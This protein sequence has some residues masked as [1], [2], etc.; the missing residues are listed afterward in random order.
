MEYKGY[1]IDDSFGD[2]YTVCYCGDEIAF[3]TPEEAMA[4]IDEIV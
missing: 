4:F 1:Y 2:F 3:S